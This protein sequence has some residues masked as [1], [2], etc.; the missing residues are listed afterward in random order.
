MKKEIFYKSLNGMEMDVDFLE[1]MLASKSL[2]YRYSFIKEHNF[3]DF[4]L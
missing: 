2:K 3:Q 4:L 1:W